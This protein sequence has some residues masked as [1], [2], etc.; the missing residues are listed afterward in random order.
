MIPCGVAHTFANLEEV[1]TRNDLSLYAGNEN[2]AWNVLND[3]IVFDWT[4]DGIR[5]APRVDVNMVPIP[6]EVNRLFYRIQQSALK[7]IR[8]DTLQ[9]GSVGAE[10]AN[11][12]L[13]HAPQW[14]T[15]ISG[16]EWGTN[17]FDEIAT[18]SWMILPGTSSCEMAMVLLQL[19]GVRSHCYTQRRDR[20]VL[21]TFLDREG[22]SV[23]LDLI[24][25]RLDDATY[26]C[27]S[28]T[29]WTCD[30]RFFL[31]IPAGVAYRPVGSGVFAVREEF[32]LPTT[33]NCRITDLADIELRGQVISLE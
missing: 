4:P 29:R 19:D 26:G 31:R 27:Y 32:D 10:H 33:K 13:V 8:M 12:R 3:N 14:E 21:L 23:E 6:L 1:V 22:I 18:G 15:G 11:A 28:L 16:C 9:H 24:D 25:L 2:S 5:S 30:P 17:C 20:D 7:A